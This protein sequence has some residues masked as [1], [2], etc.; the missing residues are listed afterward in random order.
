MGK[1]DDLVKSI[2]SEQLEKTRAEVQK[3]IDTK[4]ESSEGADDTIEESEPEPESEPE[5]KVDKLDLAMDVQLI[6]IG[7]FKHTLAL[8]WVTMGISL[9][10]LAAQVLGQSRQLDMQGKMI[11]VA[12]SQ[13]EIAKA[14]REAAEAARKN[15]TEVAEVK[16]EVKKTKEQVQEAVEASPKLEVD[17]ESGRTKVVVPVKRPKVGD[18]KNNG[19]KSAEDKDEP[20][21]KHPSKPLPAPPQVELRDEF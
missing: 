14:Q 9:V 15:A 3:E 1:A 7:K 21:V 11:V 8:I 16:E 19:D 18:K 5:E 20:E 17:P 4:K 10:A 13:L 6:M 2:T 12:E